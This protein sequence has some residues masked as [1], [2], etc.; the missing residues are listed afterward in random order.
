[1]S[2]HVFYWDQWYI[3]PASSVFIGRVDIKKALK[4]FP[5]LRVILLHDSMNILV[6]N[7]L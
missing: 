3:M 7:Y 2:W 6:S 4:A 5:C 1:M